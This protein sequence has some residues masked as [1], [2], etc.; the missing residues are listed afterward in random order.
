MR[1]GEKFMGVQSIAK[2][3]RI[4]DTWIAVKTDTFDSKTTSKLA[5]KSLEIAEEKLDSEFRPKLEEVLGYQKEEAAKFFADF[6]NEV[7]RSHAKFMKLLDN[8]KMI[9]IYCGRLNNMKE[10]KNMKEK[11]LLNIIISRREE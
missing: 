3:G 4:G 9:K 7:A 6:D 1:E 2:S 8:S 11:D 10:I 5:F